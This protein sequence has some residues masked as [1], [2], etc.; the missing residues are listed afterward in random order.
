MTGV[1]TC[2]L[3]ISVAGYGSGSFVHEYRRLEGRK[4][5][6]DAATASHTIPVTVAAEQGAIGLVAYLA[7]LAA[8]FVRLLRGAAGASVA[9]SA[10][11]AAF[12]ALVFH[13]L[14]YA[15]F[16]EDPMTWALLGLGTALAA[17]V[18]PRRAP[19]AAP[20]PRE[21][22]AAER[23]AARQASRLGTAS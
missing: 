20:P 9:R 7:L 16:L 19:A 17:T 6:P 1:Q 13:T 22:T 23:A 3:P 10:V 2:A 15:A 11:A 21:P 8:A 14:V 4:L 5:A 18:A 12:L